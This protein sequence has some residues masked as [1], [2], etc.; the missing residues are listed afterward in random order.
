MPRSHS[1]KA[2]LL[3]AILAGLVATGG[4]AA[5]A[6]D[7]TVPLLSG[8]DILAAGDSTITQGSQSSAGGSLLYPEQILSV[9][10]TAGTTGADP[11]V[12]AWRKG[13]RFFVIPVDI[14][15]RTAPGTAPRSVVVNANFRNIGN[16]VRQ[17]I[18][19][20]VFPATG[21]APDPLQGKLSAE[22]GVGADMT[23]GAT[24]PVQANAALKGALS[25]TFA[26]SS[27]TVQSGFASSSCFW[28]FVATQAEQPVGALPLK[29]TVAVPRSRQG[30]SLALVMDVTV[31]FGSR[32]WG[33]SL[34]ASFLSE[35]LLPD[36]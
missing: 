16:T 10:L 12:D 1:P 14:A 26:P 8:A 35:V 4:R 7:R 19:I 21:F 31:E 30:S 5:G 34:R 2:R 3:L 20:D 11:R 18:I 23:F 9:E 33:N 28:Q 17:P 6:A 25:Y 15:V 24:A 22:V 13:Y 29:L 27:A 32:W 36:A